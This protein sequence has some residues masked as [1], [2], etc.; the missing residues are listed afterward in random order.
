MHPDQSEWN[1]AIFSWFFG[2]HV[3]GRAVFL[4]ADEASLTA[5]SEA[6][7][8]AADSAV[9]SLQQSLRVYLEQAR[10]FE[11]WVQVADRWR[12][13]GSTAPPPFVH[14]LA[15]TVLSVTERRDA[16]APGGYYK[17]LFDTLGLKD[18]PG[19]REDYRWHVPALWRQLGTWLEEHN[20]RYGLPTA[21]PGSHGTEYLGYSRSQAVVRGADRSAFID[22]FE[23][24]GYKPGEQVSRE[25]LMAR[26]ERWA[27]PSSVSERIRHALRDPDSRDSRETIADTLLHD[28]ATWNGETRDDEFR[29]VLRVVPRLN[30]TRRSL[31]A[32]LLVP[33]VFEGLHDGETEYAAAGES[34]VFLNR[35]ISLEPNS[36]RETFVVAG[37]RLQVRHSKVHVFEEDPILGGY[38]SVDRMTQGR[39][40]WL[41]VAS[42]A[43]TSLRFLQDQGLTGQSWPSLP[44]WSI[45]RDVRL[46]WDRSASMP[47][48]LQ[49]VAPPLGLRAELRGGL[50]MGSGRYRPGGAPDLLVPACPI[51]LDIWLN[52]SLL[53]TVGPDQSLTLRLAEQAVH[54]GEYEISVG[55]QSL[56]FEIDATM[57]EADEDRYIVNVLIPDPPTL[58][59]TCRASEA[60]IDAKDRVACGAQLSPHP[61]GGVD[62]WSWQPATDGWVIFGEGGEVEVLPPD[63]PW[64]ARIGQSTCHMSLDDLTTG[65]TF[66]VRWVGRVM[67]NRVH[68][69]RLGS[70]PIS[71]VDGEQAAFFGGRTVRVDSAHAGAWSN[72]AASKLVNQSPFA[73]A[74]I[75]PTVADS[76]KPNTT[77]TALDHILQWCSDRFSGSIAYFADTFSWVEGGSSDRTHAFRALRALN[78][79]AHVEVD[80]DRQTWAI[81]PTTLVAPQNAGGVAFVAGRQVTGFRSTIED[82]IEQHN[83]DA[84]LVEAKQPI[85]GSQ[86]VFLRCGSRTSLLELGRCAGIP[87]ITHASAAFSEI[88]PS[89]DRMVKTGRIPGGFERRKIGIGPDGPTATPVWDDSWDGSYEHDTFGPKVY[90]I[91]V[92]EW[93][94]DNKYL[95]DRSTA[96]WFALRQ[97]RSL[98]I[99]YDS[100]QLT[101]AVPTKYGLPLL[102]ERSLILATGL[103]PSVVRLDDEWHYVYS[104]ISGQLFDK[105]KET[106]T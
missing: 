44:D 38:T 88:L 31:T 89:I 13:N 16:D 5:I 73:P 83:L 6:N 26:F 78:R 84:V 105:L 82:L 71:E 74:Q 61:L 51:E 98:P 68:I 48:E 57:N 7:G 76:G 17:P 21:R 97:R 14:L 35:A 50:P 39:S 104:N 10:P 69:Q 37:R 12:R 30:A 32:V 60:G 100:R 70:T 79:L 92:E 90:S 46:D 20:G 94:G 4:S 93:D 56:R 59:K 23:Q 101:L 67:S 103:L 22:F 96:L 40:A 77:R 8:W 64:L 3:K 29:S 66:R 27:S 53:T 95:V 54:D 15:L 45:F 49:S 72:F 80:W 63:P 18:T 25:I 2:D 55:D 33:S 11:H 58:I 42:S 52:G 34:R 91:C 65:V 43:R 9:K 41:A 36:H 47:E 19:R 1:E 99:Q 86:A 28:L 62:S 87:V 81:T 106:L 75:R 85:E 102:H 24:V